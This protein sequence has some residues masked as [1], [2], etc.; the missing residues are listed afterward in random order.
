[1][2]I[3]AVVRRVRWLSILALAVA[4]SIGC[5]SGSEGLVQDFTVVPIDDPAQSV[6]LSQFKDKVVL[7]DFWA[8]WCGPCR[9]SMP[10]V[11]AVWDKYHS[12]GLEVMS[13]SDEPQATIVSFHRSSPFTYPVY[14][15]A[16]QIASGLF[17]QAGIPAF[18]LVKDQKVVWQSNGYAPGIIESAVADELGH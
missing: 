16:D 7:L 13:I 12:K 4:C 14:R 1:M 10:E 15:D 2:T 8:T 17:T 3:N 18:V 11:Q 5:K 6:K 9:Q